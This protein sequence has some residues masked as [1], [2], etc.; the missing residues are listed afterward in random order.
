MIQGQ[1]NFLTSP[2]LKNSM[3]FENAPT[4]SPKK[5]DMTPP[6]NSVPRVIQYY[7][8]YSG[9]GFWRM[10]WPEHLLNAF[11]SFVVHGTTVMNLDPRYYINTKVVRIQ[12]Q[13]T[14]H[15]L[16]F[17]K[18]LKEI[19]K[20]IGFRLI[21]EI[22]DLVFSEDIPEYNKYKPA[23]TDPSIRR[24]CQE[25]MLL[26]DE[27][28]V[29]NDFMK[30]YYSEKTGHKCVTVI[31][32]FPPKF[33]LGH[34]YDEK[35]ISQNFDTHKRKPRILYA[36]SGAHFDVDNRVGQNDDFAHV[37]KAIADTCDKYQWVFL[38]A[39]PLPLRGLIQS[40]KIEFH[41][42]MNLYHYGEKIKNLN[43]NM[44]VAPLQ[45][46]NFNKSKSDLKLVEANAFGIP[47]ACQNLCTYENAQFKFDTGEEMIAKIDDVL[48]KKGRYMNLSAKARS[49]ANKRWLENPEN[50]GCYNEL[51]SFPYGDPRRVLLNKI[52]GIV[53]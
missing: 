53:A 23:F 27:I 24:N 21:Y 12:R 45:D 51:F 43:I 26:C 8:D 30:K 37:V 38:G 34:F 39:Y 10:I 44:M 47:I 4:V 13:A 14:E 5:D 46:N 22:D 41:P 15:Q 11:Q 50:I 2:L 31:P 25:I 48:S 33:W 35:K 9:C 16:K 18:F 36:G 49:D 28:T 19:S 32:N 1:N 3:R 42:W 17:V 7:A 20:E 6:E 52:N 29:T 40:G